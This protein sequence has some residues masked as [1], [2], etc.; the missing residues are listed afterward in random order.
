MPKKDVGFTLI[1][2]VVVMMVLAVLAAIVIPLYM[3]QLRKAKDSTV[4]ALLGAYRSAYNLYLTDSEGEDPSSIVDIENNVKVSKANFE[5]A[6]GA[7]GTI[8]SIQVLAGTVAKPGF[9][10]NGY[11]EFSGESNVAEMYYDSINGELYIDGTNG[12]TDYLDT[13]GEKWNE[14]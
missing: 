5:I 3:S 12:G 8:S 6:A 10:S 11:G 4:Y 9:V 14:K 7:S 1:E 13:K 2:L